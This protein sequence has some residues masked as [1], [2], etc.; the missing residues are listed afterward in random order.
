[1]I[2]VVN[3][4]NRIFYLLL[5]DTLTIIVSHFSYNHPDDGIHLIPIAHPFLL[6]FLHFDLFT[7]HLPI[8][9]INSDNTPTHIYIY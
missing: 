4:F 5:V 7:G 8:S 3:F 1:M 9:F 6:P 2:V